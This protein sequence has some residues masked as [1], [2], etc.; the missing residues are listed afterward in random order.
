MK[1]L[2]LEKIFL[3]F[4][5]FLLN[6]LKLPL[7]SSLQVVRLQ[8]S[9]V[10]SSAILPLRMSS[11]A[12]CKLDSMLLAI[13]IALIK[14]WLHFLCLNMRNNSRS[15]FNI[16]FEVVFYFRITILW[17]LAIWVTSCKSS[18]EVRGIHEA[19]SLIEIFIVYL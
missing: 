12:N 15:I 14:R 16:G 13:Q 10:T 7:H 11:T 2:N 6:T 1:A 8:A 9:V 17:D 5:A 4:I 19:T 18:L 3:I